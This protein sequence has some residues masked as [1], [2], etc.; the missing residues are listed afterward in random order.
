MPIYGSGS[1]T[2]YES[3]IRHEEIN[4]SESQEMFMVSGRRNRSGSRQGNISWKGSKP[5]DV[6]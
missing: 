2:G 4:Q 6:T 3:V 5:G 1:R